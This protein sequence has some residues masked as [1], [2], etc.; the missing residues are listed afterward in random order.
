MSCWRAP[1]PMPAPRPRVRRPPRVAHARQPARHPIAG[2]ASPAARCSPPASRSSSAPATRCSGPPAPRR[3]VGTSASNSCSSG[4]SA[5]NGEHLVEQRHRLHLDRIAE[6][7]NRAQHHV[8][9]LLGAP[10]V[11]WASIRC[12]RHRHPVPR[13]LAARLTPCLG[14]CDSAHPRPRVMHWLT[15]GPRAMRH[16]SP[17]AVTVQP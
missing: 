7:D 8:R 5:T 17:C 9:R 6:P 16:R 10:A 13:T 1:R 3:P 2:A 4:N 12:S 11:I 15:P 14:R